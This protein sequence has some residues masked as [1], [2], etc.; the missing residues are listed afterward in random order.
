[1][2]SLIRL[3]SLCPAVRART[4]NPFPLNRGG[5]LAR[6]QLNRVQ[7][8]I[9][10]RVGHPV[11]NIPP[12]AAILDQPCLTQQGHLLRNIGLAVPQVSFHVTD[13][14]FAISKNVQDG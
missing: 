1:M 9:N 10:A 5:W 4:H 13:T 8:G 2:K 6:H 7:N 14:M 3:F 12:V 11:K